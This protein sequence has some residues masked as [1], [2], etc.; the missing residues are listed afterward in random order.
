MTFSLDLVTSGQGVGLAHL[1]RETESF[2]GGLKDVI[3]EGVV[4]RRVGMVSDEGTGDFLD[5]KGDVD[6]W[7][8][9]LLPDIG[10]REAR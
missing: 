3:D 1:A 6:L 10:M 2:E 8:L 9:E 5:R 7:D 4:E